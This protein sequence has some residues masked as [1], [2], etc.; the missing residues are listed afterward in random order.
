MGST[1]EPGCLAPG[2]VPTN[3]RVLKDPDRVAKVTRK[4][5][6]SV[7]KDNTQLE[8]LEALENQVNI[9]VPM[10]AGSENNIF[11]RKAFSSSD[12]L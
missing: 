7:L 4:I 11:F 9:A 3:K 5:V 2:E 1:H 6:V 10:A 8:V 12:D